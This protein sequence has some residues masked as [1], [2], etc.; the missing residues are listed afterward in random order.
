MA[1][2]YYALVTRDA[3]TRQYEIEFPDLP[4]CVSVAGS[5][6]EAGAAAMEA[7]AAW[8]ETAV[9]RN[10]PTNQTY[11]LTRRRRCAPGRR[12]YRLAYTALPAARSR[13]G[14]CPGAGRPRNDR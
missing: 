14:R 10:R 4:G 5:L 6:Q 8:I 12:P 11:I 2:W 7:L 1:S 13:P 3:K 9:A